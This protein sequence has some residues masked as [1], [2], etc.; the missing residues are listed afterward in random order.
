MKNNILVNTI[1]ERSIM[2]RRSA[3]LLVIAAF[4]MVSTTQAYAKTESPLKKKVEEVWGKK[5]GIK[6]IQH[7]VFEKS[8]RWEFGLFVGSMPND[9]VW[10]YWPVGARIDYFIF[11]SLGIELVGAYVPATATKLQS[12]LGSNY[13]LKTQNLEQLVYY[14]G[15]NGYWAPIHGKFSAFNHEVTH[16]DVGL[17]FGAG[18]MGTKTKN[19]AGGDWK[20][21]TPS[22]YGEIGLGVQLYLTRSW[23]LRLDYRHY[24]YKAAGGGT[25][26]PAEFTIGFGWFTKAPQ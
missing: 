4:A 11:E 25:S 21:A 24:F 12:F 14:A 1:K 18:V 3:L 16:F 9:E 17:N 8:K 19:T 26:M 5:R 20:M 13:S 7:R 2:I 10:N 23:A 15:I 22:V 6:V